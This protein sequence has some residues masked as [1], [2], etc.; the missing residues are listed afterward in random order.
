[1]FQLRLGSE[2]ENLIKKLKYVLKRIL[3]FITCV[4]NLTMKIYV[5]YSQYISR[6]SWLK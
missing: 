1:M 3:T 6:I 4:I 5:E 2:L